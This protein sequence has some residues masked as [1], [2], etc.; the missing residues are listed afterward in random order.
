MHKI[1]CTRQ[2]VSKLTL[3]SFALSLHKVFAAAMLMAGAMAPHL[4]PAAPHDSIDVAILGDSNAWIG[5]DG[6]DKPAGWNK[7]FKDKFAPASCRSYARSGATWTNT[8]LTECNIAEYSETI[9]DDN[10]VYN[11]INRLAKAVDS[12]RQPAPELILI[13]AGTNDAWFAEKRP[14]AFAKTAAEAFADA[15]GSITR[16]PANS[17]LTLA[18]SVRY[19]C[20]MLMERFPDAQIVL[21]TPPQSVAAGCGNI[22]KVGDIIEECGQRMA[23]AVLRL[24]H[25][26]AIYAT[27]ERARRNNTTDGTHTSEKGARRNGYMIANWV[28]AMLQ[29]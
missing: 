28:G 24:D 19:G 12:G 27:A 3:R 17:I 4:M 5:G 9:G 14:E 21:V 20:E 16:R 10:V 6:C 25:A 15:G 8:A 26:G 2:F 11:Q 13:A 18:E 1:N 23:V 22:N 29:F 7:W